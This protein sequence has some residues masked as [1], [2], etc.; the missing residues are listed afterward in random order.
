MIQWI[1]EN[2]LPIKVVPQDE[3]GVTL[4]HGHYRKTIDPGLY[5]I[6]P[7]LDEIRTIDVQSQ[8]I[9]LPDKSITDKEGATWAVSGCVEYYVEDPK[10]AMLDVHSYDDAVQNYAGAL[11]AEAV[12]QCKSKQE[13]EDEVLDSITDKAKD[14]G[15]EV[16]GFWVNE[17]A[18]CKVYRVMGLK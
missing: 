12:F 11:V 5:W 18:K 7:L 13:I 6:F 2:L 9:D 10:M 3:R 1:K 16:T 8:L 15:L 14:W 4:R 17:L